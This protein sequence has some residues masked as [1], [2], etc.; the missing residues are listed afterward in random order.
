MSSVEF[1]LT[2]EALGKSLNYGLAEALFAAVLA[3]GKQTHGRE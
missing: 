3:K 1:H 2:A